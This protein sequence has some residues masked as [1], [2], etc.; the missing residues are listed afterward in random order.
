[1]AT[2]IAP[3][4]RF[5][6]ALGLAAALV[7]GAAGPVAADHAPWEDPSAA[8]ATAL[9]RMDAALSRGD[10]P[11]ASEAWQEAHLTALA[12]RGWEGMVAV[13]D[14]ALRLGAVT[15]TR[16]LAKATAHHSYVV[17]L[18]RARTLDSVEGALRATEAMAVLG[19]ADAVRWGLRL[20]EELV[21]RTADARAR[22]RVR[23]VVARLGRDG[24]GGDDGRERRF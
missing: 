17:A 1:M 4:A 14:G 6:W 13:G 11:V 16:H 8:W 9:A 15:R 2:T 3:H 12:I 21:G 24:L 19:D 23:E 5:G 20:A 7:A 22:A 10:V 18:F